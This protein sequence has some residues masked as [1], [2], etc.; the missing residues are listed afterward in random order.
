[1]SK[2]PTC[3]TTWMLASVIRALKEEYGAG[4]E[5]GIDSALGG[6]IMFLSWPGRA[7]DDQESYKS[8]RFPS[9]VECL[10][11]SWPVYVSEKTEAAWMTHEYPGED[12]WQGINGMVLTT[13][14]SAGKAPVWTCRDLTRFSRAFRKH[15]IV[16]RF[17][18]NRSVLEK[19]FGSRPS[20]GSGNL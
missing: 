7:E 8:F 9:N 18:P 6:G 5:F 17:A 3:L 11:Y 4:Y 16:F 20:S 19:R 13:I 14:K 15:D 1:M 12:L 10:V 2:G